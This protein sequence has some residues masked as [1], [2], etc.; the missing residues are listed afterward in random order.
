MSQRVKLKRSKFFNQVLAAPARIGWRP[1]FELT[2]ARMIPE[3][4]CLDDAEANR[5]LLAE[6]YRC[7]AVP[8]KNGAV[9]VWHPH[10]VKGD[11]PIAGCVCVS[12]AGSIDQSESRFGKDLAAL[13]V[14]LAEEAR[15]ER[16]MALR[17]GWVRAMLRLSKGE[18]D[19]ASRGGARNQTGWAQGVVD[20]TMPQF[21][22][23]PQAPTREGGLF[24]PR[25]LR[26]L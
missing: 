25:E 2:K 23:R 11:L 16:F 20:A 24:Y 4:M 26:L 14:R 10:A 22:G 21:K 7:V 8:H 9:L 6:C 18:R 15:G 5:T 13:Q 17:V 1:L 19:D 3:L 12:A